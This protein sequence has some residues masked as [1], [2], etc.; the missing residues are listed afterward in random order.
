MFALSYIRWEKRSTGKMRPSILLQLGRS[1]FKEFQRFHCTDGGAQFSDPSP[2]AHTAI[3]Q[4]NLKPYDRGF[5]LQ[6][7][8]VIYF[9]IQS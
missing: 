2:K 8:Q 6:W 4:I 7:F 5:L 9:T 1:P 3:G